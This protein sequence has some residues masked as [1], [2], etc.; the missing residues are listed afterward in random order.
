ML[1]V[2]F[3][4]AAWSR[5][6]AE[7]RRFGWQWA[8]GVLTPPPQDRVL[9]LD[10]RRARIANAVTLDDSAAIDNVLTWV[11]TARVDPADEHD[12]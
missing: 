7:S 5:M 1:P 4:K 8:L 9:L 12:T 2:R 6:E 10:P 11:D 3:A